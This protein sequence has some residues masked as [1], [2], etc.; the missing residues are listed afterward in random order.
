MKFII[1][2]NYNFKPKLFGIIEYSTA[3]LNLIWYI[4]IFCIINFFSISLIMKIFIFIIFCFPILIFS[5]VG[6]NHEKIVYVLVYLY[7]Y[8]SSQ[9]IYLYNKKWV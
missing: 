8:A 6:F 7:K 5:I 4:V 3:F 2:Q 1:P 9:K